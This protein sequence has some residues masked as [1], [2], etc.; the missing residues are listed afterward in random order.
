MLLSVEPDLAR[1]TVRRHHH[2]L[3]RRRGDEKAPRE[4]I[5]QRLLR[6]VERLGRGVAARAFLFH[7]G[8]GRGNGVRGRHRAGRCSGEQERAGGDD[9]KCRDLVGKG[10]GHELTPRVGHAW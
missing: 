7:R 4:V 1:G 6:G 3:G 5:D 8:A 9:G 10:D 2:A